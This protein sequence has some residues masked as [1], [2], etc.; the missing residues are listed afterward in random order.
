MN[1]KQTVMEILRQQLALLSEQSQKAYESN[2]SELLVAL[3]SAMVEVARFFESD[4]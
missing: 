1:E 4:R 2:D 3:T